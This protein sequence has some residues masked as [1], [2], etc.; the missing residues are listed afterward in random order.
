[1][2]SQF[3]RSQFPSS[4]LPPAQI[5]PEQTPRSH[6]SHAEPPG[7]APPSRIPLAPPQP[8]GR[9]SRHARRR[10]RAPLVFLLVVLTC[11]LTTAGLLASNRDPGS[12]A[13]ETSPGVV[14]EQVAN[15]GKPLPALVLPN[16][17]FEAGTEGWRPVSAKLTRAVP[18]RD[19]E[20]AARIAPG[21]TTE[22][23]GEESPGMRAFAVV[24]A[25]PN[26]TEVTVTVWSRALKPDTTVLLKVIE[27]QNDRSLGATSATRRLGGTKWQQLTV[28]HRVRT[29][30]AAIDVLVAAPASTTA[31]LVDSVTVRLDRATA[32]PNPRQAPASTAPLIADG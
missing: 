10:S 26:G 22:D 3:H 2:V 13:G 7:Q 1:M 6:A 18:G 32:E 8:V 16:A 17:G 30:G 25:S 21:P 19:G 14:P 28:T 27:R 12:L 20:A 15:R 4:Q 9:G 11:S 23:G 24:P 29:Q 5:P 31:F